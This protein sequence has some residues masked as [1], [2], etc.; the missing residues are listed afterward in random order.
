MDNKINVSANPHIR[1]NITTSKIMLFVIIGLLAPTLYGIY[2][3][4]LRALLIV[5]ISV[6]TCALSEY[7]FDRITKKDNTVGDLSSVVTGLLLALNL[8]VSIP[9]W[10]PVLGGV[11][12]I[13]VVKML[14]GGLGCNFMNPALAARCFLIISFPKLMTDFSYDGF[15]GAT[16]LALVKMG[17]NVNSRDMIIGN[18]PGTIGETSMLAIVIGGCFLILTGVIDMVLTGSYIGAFIIFIALFSGRGFDT[19]YLC[20]QI[21][22]G[23]LML[24]AFFMATDYVTRPVTKLGQVIYGIL[25]GF[26]TAIFRAFAPSAEGVSFAIIIGN[27]LVPLIER[28]TYRRAFGIV[29]EKK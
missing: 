18:I 12:A 13:I 19:G 20:A 21:S 8:P 23:G 24:G 7:V 27:L 2:H 14:F 17:E 11:F 1:D 4:G 25:L 15:S 6:I 5:L 26:L 3:F 9:W 22:G 10:V 28:F 16:P 29:K